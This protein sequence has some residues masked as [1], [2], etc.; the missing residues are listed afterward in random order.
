MRKQDF[1]FDL[2]QELIAQYPQPERDASRLMHCA[3]QQIH[4]RQFSELPDLLEPGDLLVFNNT[5][6][7]PARVFAQKPS[8]GRVEIMLERVLTDGKFL[9]Q[10]RASKALKP[11]MSLQTEAGPI[12]VIEKRGNFWC[13]QADNIFSLF[14]RIGHMPLPPYIKRE[15]DDVDQQRYQTIYAE[16]PGAV[17]APTAGLHFSEDIFS[18]LKQRGVE[19]AFVTLHV[20]AGTYQPVRADDI[21]QHQMHHEYCEITPSVCERIN[22]TKANGKRVIAVGTTSVRVLETAAKQ[23]Q[24]EPYQGDT[25]IFIYPG[26]DFSIIDGL[27][28]NF[29]LPES[30]LIMLVSALAGK[31][32]ILEA[33]Q[34]AVKNQY[35]FFSYG[36]AMF[37]E[38]KK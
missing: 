23:G 5:R 25:N 10:C 27:V 30:S 35:R 24:V 32:F 29:H 9:C 16:K 15:D 31:D 28:T 22:K 19:Q 37:I 26:Y 34:Q 11:S 12:D 3:G 33:Y 17:A 8:G 13:L 20:A 2:P 7:I 21:T 36:D 4:H 6:V 14:E 38:T 18:R 1:S